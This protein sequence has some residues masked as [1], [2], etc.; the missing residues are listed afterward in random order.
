ML[1]LTTVLGALG[2]TTS[3]TAPRTATTVPG[4]PKLALMAS[5]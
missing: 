5:T 4:S 3:A 2:Q 1:F